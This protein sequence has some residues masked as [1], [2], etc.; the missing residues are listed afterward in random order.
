MKKRYNK[1]WKK[2]REKKGNEKNSTKK[3]ATI[4]TTGKG[5]INKRP[6]VW[7]GVVIGREGKNGESNYEQAG[8]YYKCFECNDCVEGKKKDLPEL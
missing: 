4:K 1:L 8:K 7:K 2:S 3:G 5:A 6:T